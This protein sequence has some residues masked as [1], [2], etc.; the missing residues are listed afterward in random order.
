MIVRAVHSGDATRL[1]ELFTAQGFDYE[2]PDVRSFVAAQGVEDD[3]QFVQAVLAR[4]T[5][6]LYFLADPTWKTP[7]YRHEGLRKVHESMRLELAAKGFEDAHVFLPPEKSKSF[8]RRLMQEFG[9]TH[10]LWF[11]LTRS[12][13]PRNS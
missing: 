1:Q 3:G 13:A 2:L 5:V 11:A 10:P 9:W 12:T 4:P 6:E 8:A 7:G